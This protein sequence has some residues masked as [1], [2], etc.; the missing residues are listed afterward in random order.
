MSYLTEQKT[1]L[2]QAQV[3]EALNRMAKLGLLENVINEFHQ[4]GRINKS[5]IYGILYWLDDEEEK[6]VREWEES[7]K[8]KQGTLFTM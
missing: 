5:E 1:E 7:G 3:T 2:Q 8:R 4:T 6:M